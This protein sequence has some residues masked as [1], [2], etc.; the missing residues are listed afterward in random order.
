MKLG[1]LSSIAASA[2]VLSVGACRAD[3]W[4]CQVLLCLANPGGATQYAECVPPITKLWDEL[5]KGHAFPTCSGVGFTAS[6]PVYQPYS[7]PAGYVLATRVPVAQGIAGQALAEGQ[8][9]EI[10]CLA[11]ERPK[12]R[13]DGT[14]QSASVWSLGNGEALCADSAETVVPA[15]VNPQPNYVDVT[16]EGRGTQ[17]IWF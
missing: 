2:L 9:Q 7:C 1:Y 3:D 5:R 14:H 17:R 10:A 6:K 12:C 13:P 8:A 15:T 4:G 16:I 11:V